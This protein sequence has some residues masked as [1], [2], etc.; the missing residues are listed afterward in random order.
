MGV[1]PL[2]QEELRSEPWGEL[3]VWMFVNLNGGLGLKGIQWLSQGFS[4]PSQ[5]GHK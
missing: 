2:K 3:L 5:L 1:P 4:G